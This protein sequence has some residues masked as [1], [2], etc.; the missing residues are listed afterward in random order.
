M[1]TKRN[2]VA[3]TAPQ[4]QTSPKALATENDDDQLATTIDQTPVAKA[5]LC[6]KPTAEKLPGTAKTAKLVLAVEYFRGW[7]KD[8]LDGEALGKELAG[9]LK[10]FLKTNKAELHF[11]RRPGRAGQEREQLGTRQLFIA[12]AD[13]QRAGFNPDQPYTPI[14]EEMQITDVRQLLD[15]D[16]SQPGVNP[17]ATTV[18]RNILLICTHARRDRCC[19]IFGRPVAAEV[20]KDYDEV[21]ESSHTKGHRFA[22]SMILL[23]SNYSF[24]RLTSD[25]TRYMLDGART[26]KLT[27]HNNRGR[28]TLT[29]PAQVAELEV[30]RRLLGLGIEPGLN[31]FATHETTVEVVRDSQGAK[32]KTVKVEVLHFPTQRSFRAHLTQTDPIEVLTSCGDALKKQR[33]WRVKVLEE[34]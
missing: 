32:S 27:F 22:P 5:D 20:S 28:G 25:E 12:W 13:A 16:L 18:D 1:S 15:L 4:S 31:D 21:W 2:P 34:I 17:Q 11:I 8:I 14:L 10:K 7:G 26:H 23:P 24:G 9:E 6:A 29:P 33:G 30:A 19:A 3:G